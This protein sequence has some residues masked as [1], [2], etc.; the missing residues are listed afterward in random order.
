MIGLWSV[1][2]NLIAHPLMVLLPRRWGDA[3]HD[4][5]ADKAFGTAAQFTSA[6]PKEKP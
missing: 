6:A 3:F 4:W 2:H 5:T 1:I